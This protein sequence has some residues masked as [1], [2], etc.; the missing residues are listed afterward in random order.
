MH[1]N[2][3]AGS[4]DRANENENAVGRQRKAHLIKQ[5]MQ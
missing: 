5:K 2:Q 3:Q 1:P 4:V